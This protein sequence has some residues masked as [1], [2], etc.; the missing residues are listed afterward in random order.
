M[1]NRKA[2]IQNMS[3]GLISPAI[4]YFGKFDFSINPA[5]EVIVKN[6]NEGETYYVRENTPLTIHLSKN[7][8]I[9]GI[10][11]CSE[12]ILPGNGIPI[13]KHLYEDEI[14]FFMKGSGLVIVEKTEYKI[15][16]GST[17]YVPKGSWHGIKNTGTDLL[18]F[19]FGYSPAGFEDFFRQIGTPK[20]A[21]FKAK[22]PEESKLIAAKYG[23]VFK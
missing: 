7:D 1:K 12:E 5:K 6:A 8:N 13:H 4:G 21:P 10:S 17:A 23:M 20:G 14:F 22:T 9:D 11:I 18:I 16:A 15:S 3:L 19:T 2:F